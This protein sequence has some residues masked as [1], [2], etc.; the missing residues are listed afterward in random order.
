[1]VCVVRMVK[2]RNSPKT[3]TVPQ[4]LIFHCAAEV[5]QPRNDA[6]WEIAR[7]G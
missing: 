6:Q 5:N 4:M 1:M 3:P 7:I 2:T